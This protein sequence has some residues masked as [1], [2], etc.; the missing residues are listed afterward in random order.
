MKNIALFI[1]PFIFSSCAL[2]T[3]L[4]H[5]YADLAEVYSDSSW[6][7]SRCHKKDLSDTYQKIATSY[8]DSANK[9]YLMGHPH[10]FDPVDYQPKCNCK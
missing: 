4:N 7:A 3:R 10:A 8:M 9:Y 1:L 5:K 2:S 6:C